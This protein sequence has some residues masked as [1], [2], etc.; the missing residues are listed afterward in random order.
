MGSDGFES[1]KLG[2]PVAGGGTVNTRLG[3]NEFSVGGTRDV[4]IDALSGLGENL[5]ELTGVI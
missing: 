1:K 3:T 5:V 4:A 2:V